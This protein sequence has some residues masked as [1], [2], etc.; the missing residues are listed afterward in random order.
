MDLLQT[1][2]VYMSLVFTAS[3]Q[4]AP[5]PSIIP[6]VTIPPAGYS[7]S[8]ISPTAA[9][10]PVPTIAITPNPAY[11]TLKMGDKGNEVR[12]LQETLK[13]YGYY[14]AEVD[15]A[16]GNQTRQAV[17]RFQYMHGLSADGMAGRHTLTVLYESNQVRLPE[18]VNATPEPT[19][20]TKLTV[21]FTPTPT[22]EATPAPTEMPVITETPA[23]E[24]T[25]EVIVPKSEPPKLMEGTT[26]IYDAAE[27]TW[28]VFE[29][30]GTLYLPVLEMLKEANVYVISSSS[31]ELDEYAYALGM[32]FMRFSFVQNQQGDPVGLQVFCNDVLQEIG[33]DTLY[34][35]GDTLYL[36]TEAIEVLTGMSVSLDE[37]S[38]SVW[39]VAAQ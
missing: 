23:P 36:P 20:E 13:E 37:E 12:K 15:G 38:N 8:V 33:I 2:L 29:G 21:A 34:K 16:Y 26:V 9:P 35:E 18:G 7:Q 4:N 19:T 11:S 24:P 1:L 10:T 17:E 31:L 39:I 27:T 30:D 25:A 28:K 22:P 6:A 3:V 5:E 14:T 32:N